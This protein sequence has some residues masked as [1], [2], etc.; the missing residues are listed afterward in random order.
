[1]VYSLLL[2]F[3]V[4]FPCPTIDLLLSFA[5]PIGWNGTAVAVYAV[6]KCLQVN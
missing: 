2:V 4:S 5:I 3:A 6:L 1:M